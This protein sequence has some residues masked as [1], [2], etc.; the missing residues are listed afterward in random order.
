METQGRQAKGVVLL[1]RV[2]GRRA[3][4][5]LGG[6]WGREWLFLAE[7]ILSNHK[8]NSENLG[9]SPR[10]IDAQRPL[11]ERQAPNACAEKYC[12]H[13]KKLTD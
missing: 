1:G 12:I 3:A 10:H 2:E 11:L 8:Y 6:C 9:Q 4:W 7:K 5:Q 13:Q